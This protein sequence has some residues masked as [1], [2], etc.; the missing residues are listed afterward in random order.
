MYR[1]SKEKSVIYRETYLNGIRRL[2]A[3]R[4]L[5]CDA[6]RGRFI[7]P[8]LLAARQEHYREA[9]KQLLGWPLTE[10]MSAGRPALLEHHVADTEIAST[11]RVQ[12]EVFDNFW[13]YGL[14]VIPAHCEKKLPL[15]I[16][17][18]GG[19]GT[20]ELVCGMHGDNHYDGIVWRL[21]TRQTAVFLPQ[22]LL[23]RESEVDQDCFPGYGL[24]YNRAKTDAQLK[25][26]GSSIT[27]LEVY[28]LIRSLDSLQVFNFIDH[29]HI[30]MIG[31][32]YGGF[33]TL[34]TAAL[35][36]RIRAGYAS[37]FFNNRYRY[38]SPDFT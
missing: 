11:R 23:W 29:E 22:M 17:Q 27:A 19:Y 2:I 32:S 34:M 24:P 6:A 33:Y 31:L 20:P 7:T 10:S 12:I 14:L 30:G 4:Q 21:V 3:Q 18:H 28:C 15:I 37:A 9:L 8:A 36:P 13:Y 16:C 1:E 38:S 5:L 26:T 35:E 25:Q